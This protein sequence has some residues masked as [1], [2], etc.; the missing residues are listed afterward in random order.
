MVKN[1]IK[2]VDEYTMLFGIWIAKFI[3][4][5]FKPLKFWWADRMI[6]ACG[7][8]ENNGDVVIIY[9]PACNTR[10]HQLCASKD[11]L[12][13]KR[14]APPLNAVH[15][16]VLKGEKGSMFAVRIPQNGRTNFFIRAKNPLRTVFSRT[17]ERYQS[18][19]LFQASRFRVAK[20]PRLQFFFENIYNKNFWFSFLT[21][22][23]NSGTLVSGIYTKKK[24]WAFSDVKNLPYYIHDPRK[25]VLVPGKTYKA[26]L[27]TVNRYNWVT[28]IDTLTFS[29]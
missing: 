24:S 8:Q 1:F 10:G 26:V 14:S 6:L 27:Y 2:R 11:Y 5:F 3:P 29:S 7:Y 16:V 15:A 4:L 23:D 9:R 21:I 17:V 25:A 19:T 12:F 22:E 13:W 28:H 18:S 20:N